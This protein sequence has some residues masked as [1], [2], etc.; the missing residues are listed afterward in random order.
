[1]NAYTDMTDAEIFNAVET[2]EKAIARRNATES[3]KASNR[4]LISG[5]QAEA[6][7]RLRVKEAKAEQ[8]KA[9]RAER[10][11]QRGDMETF[12][13]SA[14]RPDMPEG[15]SV[16]ASA[17]RMALSHIQRADAEV[18]KLTDRLARDPASALEWSKDTFHA[19]AY[20]KVAKDYLAS[21]EGG[22]THA[23]ILRQATKEALRKGGS[24]AQSTSPTS[25]LMDDYIRAATVDLAEKL[26]GY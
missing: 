5:L 21:V 19:V 8:V 2:A 12:A 9:E 18:A 22:W 26:N 17:A 7:R 13:R 20:A 6:A 23:E 25:N 14:Y 16:L 10:A 24:M 1:M 15:E 4:A 3:S 11:A